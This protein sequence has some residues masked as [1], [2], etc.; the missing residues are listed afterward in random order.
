[1]NLIINGIKT[2]E[3]EAH[4][5]VQTIN[6]IGP[7]WNILWIKKHELRSMHA[8][9]LWI[10]KMLLLNKEFCFYKKISYCYMNIK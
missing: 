3:N 5:N 9:Y 8:T 7:T 1:M 4:S 10:Q 2:I 6:V